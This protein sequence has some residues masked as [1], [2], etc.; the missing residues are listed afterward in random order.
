MYD[1]PSPWIAIVTWVED[2]LQNTSTK[3]LSTIY[4]RAGRVEGR[5]K[6]NRLA[7]VTQDGIHGGSLMFLT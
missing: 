5:L 3:D 2:R 1:V 7:F 6:L 4:E